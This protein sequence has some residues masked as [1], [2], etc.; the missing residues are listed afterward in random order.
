M[1]EPLLKVKR[2]K[3][4]KHRSQIDMYFLTEVTTS[5]RVRIIGYITPEYLAEAG[6]EVNEGETYKPDDERRRFRSHADNIV[7]EPDDLRIVWRR[8]E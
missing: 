8:E 6:T 2:E 1:G 7:A 5:G 3:F 4:E